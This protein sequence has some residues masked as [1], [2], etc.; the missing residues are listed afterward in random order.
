MI[1]RKT[2]QETMTKM[3]GAS[4]KNHVTVAWKEKTETILT[5][6][7]NVHQHYCSS[8]CVCVCE[9]ERERV[10]ASAQLCFSIKD[11]R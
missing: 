5:E 1:V 2:S 11:S 3:A 6:Y 7:S 4:Q 9:R 8:V 10:R